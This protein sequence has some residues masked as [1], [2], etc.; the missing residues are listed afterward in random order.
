MTFAYTSFYAQFHIDPHHDGIILKPAIDVFYGKKL[1]VDSFTQYGALTTLIHAFFFKLFG[2]TLIVQRLSAVVTYAGIS[3]LL[4]LLSRRL[5]S[6]LFSAGV[7][8]FWIATMYFPN[9]DLMVPLLAWSSVYSLFFQLATILLIDKFLQTKR[10]KF[11]SVAGASVALTFWCR[12][13][14]GIFLFLAISTFFVI[15]LLFLSK[16]E[17]MKGYFY[18]LMGSIVISV[19]FLLWLASYHGLHDWWQ[20]SIIL[21]F[22]FGKNLSGTFSLTPIYTALLPSLS[23]SKK[24]LFWNL[25]TF[26]TVFVFALESLLIFYRKSKSSYVNWFLFVFTLVGLASWMQFFPGNDQS[27]VFWAAT[28]MIPI[29]FYVVSESKRFLKKYGS[30]ELRINEKA[31]SRLLGVVISIVVTGLAM[32]FLVTDIKSARYYL[33]RKFTIVQDPP[34]LRGMKTPQEEQIVLDRFTQLLNLYFSWYPDKTYISAS[35]DALYTLMDPHYTS[36]HRSPVYWDWA[37]RDVFSDYL[38]ALHAYITLHRPLVVVRDPLEFDNYCSREIA[39]HYPVKTAMYQRD[40]FVRIPAEDLLQTK[41]VGTQVSLLALKEPLT[42]IVASK[43]ATLALN[44]KM[45]VKLPISNEKYSIHFSSA[46]FGNCDLS[47]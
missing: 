32:L 21:A 35:P 24:N 23:A 39:I 30:E 26:T 9:Q 27:H 31:F 28:P 36:I 22:T 29:F 1:F 6:P 46:N 15:R 16:P 34:V 10:C 17:S 3:I 7:V 40:L 38:P 11:L 33:T 44:Q 45:Q 2:P 37:M 4:Y 14:V 25:T 18:F 8:L 43:S 13:P 47:P 5:L 12:Q 42:I 19:P 20:Q 41:V